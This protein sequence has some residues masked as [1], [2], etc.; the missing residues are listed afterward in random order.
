MSLAEIR[1]LC[2][3]YGEKIIVKNVSFS[4]ESGEICGILG[5]NGCG[6]TTLLKAICGILPH[7][8]QC[9][10]NG[11]VLEGMPPKKLGQLCGYIPQRSGISIDIS[12][13]D[14]V[15]MGFNPVLGLL[16]RP[17]ASM[18]EK[19][20]AVLGEAGLSG[21]ADHNYLHLSEGQKQL[22]IL[23][24]ALVSDARLLLLDEPESGLDFRHR[25]AAFALLK[26]RMRE[27]DC[28]A[29]VTLHDPGLAL[30]RCDKLILLN[31]GEVSAVLEPGKDT[32]EKM[33]RELSEIYGSVSV[34]RVKDRCGHERLVM[35]GEDEN[36]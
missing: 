13:L 25:G 6:K 2:A 20:R 33:G 15:L 35:I 17:T 12:V 36:D 21:L 11:T 8:G 5:A 30:N 22:C 3:G 1:D 19:A 4:L 10:V 7:N 23:T 32:A 34:H 28:A 14:V 9:S 31:Q 18:T 24:R 29:L 27:N 26:R 16:E